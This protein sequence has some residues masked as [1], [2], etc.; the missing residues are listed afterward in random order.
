MSIKVVLQLLLHV[1]KDPINSPPN[2]FTSYIAA[3]F[4]LPV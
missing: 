3:V 2:L 1:V 4:F